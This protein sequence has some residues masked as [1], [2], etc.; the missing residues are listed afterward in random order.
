MAGFAHFL[1]DIGSARLW[2][3]RVRVLQAVVHNVATN[4]DAERDQPS[5]VTEASGAQQY[6]KRILRR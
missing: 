3:G 1:S 6:G 5:L 2:I 4:G